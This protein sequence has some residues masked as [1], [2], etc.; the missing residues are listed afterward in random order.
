MD[1]FHTSQYFGLEWGFSE[2][3]LFAGICKSPIQ[4]RGIAVATMTKEQ[5]RAFL[6]KVFASMSRFAAIER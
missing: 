3:M 6:E 4:V 5:A 2:I 1:E